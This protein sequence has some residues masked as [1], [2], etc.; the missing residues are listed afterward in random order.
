MVY[1]V[2]SDVVGQVKRYGADWMRRWPSCT[3]I[4]TEVSP[5]WRGCCLRGCHCRAFG[6][7]VISLITDQISLLP[8]C[9]RLAF[10]HAHS[11][12]VIEW[13]REGGRECEWVGFNV[14]IDT[15]PVPVQMI[16]WKDSSPKWP[17]NVL[18]GTLNPT[19]SLT[20]HIGKMMLK[21]QYDNWQ[22]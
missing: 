8:C 10:A 14:P 11:E 12:W 6:E 15:L 16:D 18:M 19:H 21:V 17:Y 3:G 22:G 9:F 5:P 1:N 7:R 13:G 4:W 20:Y 2:R